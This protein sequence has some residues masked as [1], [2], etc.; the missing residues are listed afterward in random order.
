MDAVLK[1]HPGICSSA[2]RVIL[3]AVLL[4]ILARGTYGEDFEGQSCAEDHGHVRILRHP[5]FSFQPLYPGC[6]AKVMVE[7]SR[8][9][10]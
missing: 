3:L 4:G 5:A 1:T 7:F 8:R 6:L 2:F 9:I 10:Y